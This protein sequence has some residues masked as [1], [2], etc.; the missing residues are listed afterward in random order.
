M[1]PCTPG[2]LAAHLDL[3]TRYIEEWCR[4]QA[5]AGVISHA[6]G[7]FWL[8]EV[9]QDVLVREHG[10]EQSPFFAVG[11]FQ[12]LPGLNEIAGKKLAGLF[13]SGEGFDYDSYPM[14]V[15]CGTFRELVSAGGAVAGR[16][17]LLVGV[18]V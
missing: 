17:G 12:A 11:G 1:G 14:E 2:A 6:D 4:Q 18:I 7:T 10:P 8:T 15:T 5:S 13:R 16:E 3:A 9:Q